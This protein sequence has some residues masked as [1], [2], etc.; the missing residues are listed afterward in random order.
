M[1]NASLLVAVV[2]PQNSEYGIRCPSI[3]PVLSQPPELLGATDMMSD[4][5]D[6]FGEKLFHLVCFTR[7]IN[8]TGGPAASIPLHW[9]ADGL[10]VGVHF[11]ADFGS[12]AVLFRLAAQLEQARPWRDRRP[13]RR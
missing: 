13:P 2:K 12:E 10:P 7:Q 3:T 6:A 9:T 1:P 5:L 8:V 11:V 4:D